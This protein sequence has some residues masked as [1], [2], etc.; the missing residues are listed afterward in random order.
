MRFMAM[1]GAAALAMALAACSGGTGTTSDAVMN[2]TAFGNDMGLDNMV[3]GNMMA[4][5]GAAI[6]ALKT[7]DG[8]DAGSATVTEADGALHVALTARS[9]EHTSELQ[10]L[11]RLSYA[12]F[13][14]KHRQEL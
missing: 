12:V 11:M 3:D 2:D 6:A 9:E 8:K 14:L 1:T 7:A 5:G 13:C 10:S 4:A